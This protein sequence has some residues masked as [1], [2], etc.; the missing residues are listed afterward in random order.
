MDYEIEFRLI[1]I[2]NINKIQKIEKVEDST[3][4]NIRVVDCKHDITDEYC[5]DIMYYVM[6]KL[7]S[8]GVS[9]YIGCT[10]RIGHYEFE[11]E[12]MGVKYTVIFQQDTY[13]WNL[14]LT[15]GVGYKTDKSELPDEYD[16]FLEKLKLCIKNS[17]I[18]DWYKCIW[19]IDNQS[20]SL[21]REVYSEIYIA[22]NEL[23]AFISK[24]MIENFG[25]DWHDKPEFTK[26][27]A[28]I[29]QNS[30]DI[31]RNVPSFAN[32]DVNL[33]TLTL[34]SL[35]ETIKADIYTDVMPDS[36]EIQK[37][38]KSKIFATTKLDKMQSA[39]DY[40]R[41]RYT[42]KYNVQER[43][44][45]PFI[46]DTVKWQEALSNFIANR[47]HV[48][49]N[50]LLDFSAKVKMLH[51]T[52]EFREYIK[53]AVRK[54]DNEVRSLEVEETMQA[55][56]DQI[57]YERE[58]QLEI[59]QSEAGIMIRDKKKILEIFREV[60]KDIYTDVYEV[61]YFD[62][63]LDIDEISTLQ[64]EQ[65]EQLLFT[66]IDGQRV[67]LSVYGLV[68]I[69]DAEGATSTLKISVVGENDEDV[70]TEYIEYINGEAEYNS[71][72]TSYMPVVEDSLD[73]GNKVAIKEAIDTFLRRIIEEWDTMSYSE[74]RRAKEDWDAD[75]ADMLE[76]R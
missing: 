47:N 39:L 75:A 43:F 1:D 25:A 70:A 21:S 10:D 76:G 24:V 8:E 46:N 34:E 63:K 58:A 20:L 56:E 61:L 64:Y 12:S 40:L 44:F 16:S 32:I 60:I 68:D 38:I 49:H 35:M 4:G 69:D 53:S 67:L 3:F 41:A 31:K 51:D 5:K 30:G 18:R 9:K 55:I 45:D 22:E 28:S 19:I 2:K 57:E 52:G 33:Y 74:E 50:K 42:K 26:L 11:V 17:M 73:D 59:V 72:Q 13:E 27:N 15:V 54:F 14:Q 37:A 23:R 65:D 62:E 66:I 7:K 71:E 29:E 6:T 36:P 48:A